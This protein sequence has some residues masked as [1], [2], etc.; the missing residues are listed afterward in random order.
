MNSIFGKLY[1]QLVDIGIR[2]HMP[3]LRVLIDRNLENFALTAEG[4]VQTKTVQWGSHT[5]N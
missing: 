4:V 1:D 2:N 3:L 5:A